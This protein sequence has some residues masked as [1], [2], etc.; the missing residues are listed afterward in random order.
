MKILYVS[1]SQELKTFI[2]IYKITFFTVWHHMRDWCFSLVITD[3]ISWQWCSILC[4][5]IS[6]SLRSSGQTIHK[7][8]TSQKYWNLIVDANLNLPHPTLQTGLSDILV[9]FFLCMHFGLIASF[10]YKQKQFL[11]FFSHFWIC[12]TL[13]IWLFGFTT[14][15]VFSTS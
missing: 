3:Q 9:I 8:S 11:F 1:M 4:E 5:L 13:W 14:L 6:S 2:K 10:L 7:V 12:L 15:I